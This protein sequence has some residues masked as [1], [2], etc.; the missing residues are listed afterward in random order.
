[1]K[2]LAVW[3]AVGAGTL[4]T[5]SIALYIFHGSGSA[6]RRDASRQAAQEDPIAAFLAA[7]WAN[8][9]PPQGA[10]PAQF[11]PLEASLAPEACGQC[12][13]QQYHDWRDSLHRRTVGPGLLWQFHMMDQQA[14]N[15]CM[16]C[17]APLAEQK[18]LMAL[19]RGWSGVPS[20]PP[21]S[22]V[23]PNL[24]RE[25]LVCAGCHVRAHQRFGPPPRNP[26]TANPPPHGGFHPNAAFEDS[27]FCA[28]CH[29]F[30]ESG[31]RLN[32]KLL[33]NTYEEWRNSLPG[34][35]GQTCQSCHMPD[36]RHL[37]RGIHDPQMTAR[38]LT[39]AIDL[40]ERDREHMLVQASIT[41]TGA[42]HYFPTYV[43]PE[44]VF[45]LRLIDPAGRRQGEIAHT[46]VA[47]RANVELTQ[48]R[49]DHR[50]RSGETR[51]LSGV[52]KRPAGA[53]W[54]IELDMAVAPGAHYHRS[55]RYALEHVSHMKPDTRK[56][57]QQALR[58]VDAARYQVTLART[59]IR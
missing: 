48:E 10:P 1:M 32:G 42:G 28:V 27:R 43:V 46:V 57:L 58:Q 52:V 49:F 39:V 50:I 23:P 37:W 13:V 22:Y 24:H 9:L 3:A 17:H 8:P 2:K 54:S 30:P 45:T 21:P 7:H 11:S 5:A 15:A 40:Y 29:Q 14:A 51:I 53:G 56:L 35:A 18:A 36:R 31:S 4:I 19:E 38:A 59:A 16:R 34:R 47:R 20:P 55:F 25:G 44:I 12:H 33:E 6:L 26:S 41:N